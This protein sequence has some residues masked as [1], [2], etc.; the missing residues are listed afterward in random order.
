MAMDKE[1]HEAANNISIDA[2]PEEEMNQ[3]NK[4]VT[5]KITKSK[6]SDEEG[7]QLLGNVPESKMPSTHSFMQFVGMTKA[8]PK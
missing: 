2:R 1:A 3:K 6:I 5:K 7:Q 8:S 4:V